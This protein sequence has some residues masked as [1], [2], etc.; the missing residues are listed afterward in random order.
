[1]YKLCWNETRFN[2]G[3]AMTKEQEK[4]IERLNRFKTIE[5]LYGNTFAMHIEQLKTVQGDIETV[6]SMLQEQ[7]EENKKKDKI[8]DLMAECIDVELSSARLGTIL[9]KNVKPL[10]TYKEEVK[11]Y[12]K[13][14]AEKE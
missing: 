12:F 9:N 8:I 10:E 6:L 5:I 14:K 1:M 4:A 11:Q 13:S 7:Q 3:Q 2:G